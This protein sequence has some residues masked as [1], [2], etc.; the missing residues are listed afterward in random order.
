MDERESN[1]FDE[2]TTLSMWAHEQELEYWQQELTN[3]PGY[4]DWLRQVANEVNDHGNH[5]I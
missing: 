1:D 2:D 3:D 4:F 5:R